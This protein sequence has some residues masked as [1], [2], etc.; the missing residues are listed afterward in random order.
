MYW[1]VCAVLTCGE[2]NG[3]VAGDSMLLIVIRKGIPHIL[4]SNIV[5]FHDAERTFT[6][7]SYTS[8]H[9]S[10]MCQR[11]RI[12]VFGIS[13]VTTGGLYRGP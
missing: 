1:V 4:L 12:E 5:G 2:V 7:S 3:T 6:L 10:S 11:I 8:R 13:G 9:S